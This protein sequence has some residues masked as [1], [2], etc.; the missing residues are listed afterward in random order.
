VAGASV[1]SAAWFSALG[2]GARW[3]APWFAHPKAWQV[4]DAL[5][6]LTMWLLAAL[7]LRHAL[8]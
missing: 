6:A 7:M 4:L 3:L 1:A 2:F 8:V 5:I